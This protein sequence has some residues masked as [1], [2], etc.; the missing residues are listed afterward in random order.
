MVAVVDDDEGVRESLRF[1]LETAGFRVETFA[2]GDQF[3]ATCRRD[4][5]CLVV[6]QNMPQL[7]GIELL[8]RLRARGCNLQVALMTGS[9][10]HDLT[11]RARELGA[12]MVLEKPLQDDALLQFVCRA[13]H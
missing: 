10:S 3:L 6:D 7:T 8:Q 12:A 13:A 5:A 1:L 2:S 9:P 4:R 11:R